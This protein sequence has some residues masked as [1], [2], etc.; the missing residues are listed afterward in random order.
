MKTKNIPNPKHPVARAFFG[1]KKYPVV[2]PGPIV[3]GTP[4]IKKRLPSL[5]NVLLKNKLIPS[6]VN[7]NPAPS[8][9]KPTC[10]FPLRSI[11]PTSGILDK[12]D[13]LDFFL[14]NFTYFS[15]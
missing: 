11:P 8:K 2:R 5:I 14:C 13:D 6:I 15:N 3:I 12:G 1:C 9:A 7:T 10:L 4:A